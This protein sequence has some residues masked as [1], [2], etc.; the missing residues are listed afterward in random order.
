MTS[1]CTW[2]L[3]SL[4]A[5]LIAASGCDD[6]FGDKARHKFQK[7]ECRGALSLARTN[8]DSVAITRARPNGWGLGLNGSV[9]A[10]II[11]HDSKV[12]P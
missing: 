4:G 7:D 12:K 9:C 6:P 11:A 5:V 8:A 10:V 2:R 1:K 3:A